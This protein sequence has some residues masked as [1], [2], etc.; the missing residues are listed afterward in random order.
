MLWLI[1]V[2]AAFNGA[3]VGLILLLQTR[4]GPS[5]PR[6]TLSAFLILT[7]VQLGLFVALDRAWIRYSDALG[8][9]LDVAALL[10]AGL[11]LDYV[12]SSLSQKAQDF[13]P[14]LPGAIY[15]VFCLV[16]GRRFGEPGDYT[17]IVGAQIAYTAVAIYVYSAALRRFSDSWARRPEQRHLPMLLGGLILLHIG[18]VLRFAAPA[19]SLIF[20]L[21][22][23]AGA[24]G[25]LAFSIYA[26]AGSQ[27]LRHLAANRRPEKEDE[28]LAAKIETEIVATRAFLDPD[29]SLARAAKALDTPAPRFSAYL[30]RT[31]GLTF[32]AY[33]NA[34]RVEEAKRLLRAPEEQRTSVDAIAQLSGFR[35]RSSFYAA[36]Q[37]QVGM[38]PQDYRAS[39]T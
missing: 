15:L 7:A 9:G 12:R 33:V 18:Q 16:N 31:R 11:V 6:L 37:A 28:A 19:N 14:Y 1:E 30:N 38:T 23:L 8:V 5:R 4:A 10:T 13:Y 27:T 21:A 25:L 22:P 32:R 26:L 35:S 3:L 36:F 29:L 34:L 17:L 39:A 24:I 20:E 2:I